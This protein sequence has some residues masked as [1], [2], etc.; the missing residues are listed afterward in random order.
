MA[1]TSDPA[2]QDALRSLHPGPTLEEE[3]HMA[4]E[5]GVRPHQTDRTCF[6]E[7]FQ[8]TP[9]ERGL[10][11]HSVSYEECTMYYHSGLEEREVLFRIVC[12]INNG[13]MHPDAGYVL[14]DCYLYALSKPDGGARPIGVGAA[15]RRLAGWVLMKHRSDDIRT[16]LTGTAPDADM[17]RRAGHAGDRRCNTLLQ[18][19]VGTPPTPGGA[20]ILFKLC[21]LAL[22]SR[23]TGAILSNDF[24]NGFNSISRAAIFRGLRRWFPELIPT[25]RFFYANTARLWTRAG[26]DAGGRELAR[27]SHGVVFGSQEGCTQGDPLGPLLW[28]IGYHMSLLET[29]AKHPDTTILA[30][31][32]DTYFFDEIIAAAVAAL[33]SGKEDTLRLCGVNSKLTKQDAF[34][35]AGD[36]SGVPRTSR[37]RRRC[38][39][40]AP[41][42]SGS[43]P[44]RCSAPSSA[45]TRR[46]PLG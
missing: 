8:S 9:K 14:R 42:A 6:N 29:Q 25:A 44:S 2:V 20:E 18:L 4:D 16:V 19:G 31:L 39:P 41:L 28:A 32:D 1:D 34:S 40:M 23:P 30:Y 13:T 5:P 37:A 36:L 15:L 11:G 10:G 33:K 21:S 45:T 43:A 3:A 35:P 7:V 17:L 27:D 24:S 46:R 26:A 38:R 22:A 12:A